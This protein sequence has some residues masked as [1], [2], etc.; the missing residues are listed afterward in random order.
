MIDSFLLA[1][2]WGRFHPISHSNAYYTWNPYTQ[3][4]EPILADQASWEK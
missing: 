2:V 3:K 4:L 1:L